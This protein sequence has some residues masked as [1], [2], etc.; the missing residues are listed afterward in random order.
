MKPTS[1]GACCKRKQSCCWSGDGGILLSPPDK[2]YNLYPDG[3]DSSRYN[4]TPTIAFHA[5]RVYVHCTESTTAN[6]ADVFSK[7]PSTG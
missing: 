5:F 7:H 1:C 2:I 4:K 3:S 6:V